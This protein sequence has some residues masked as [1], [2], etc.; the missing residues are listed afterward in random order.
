MLL[1]IDAEDG[2]PGGHGPITVY[3]TIVSNLLAQVSNGHSG[4]LVIGGGKD[5][6]DDVTTFWD[7]IG[8]A[9]G[10]SVTY[11]NGTSNISSQSFAGFA[12]IVVSSSES[13]TSSGGLTDAENTALTAR[14]ISIASHVNGGGALMVF[15]QMG[16]TS[17]YG[18]LAGIGAITSS[19][20][21]S[22]DDENIDVNAAGTAA[23]LSDELD[24]CCWHEQYLSFPSFL[25]PLATYAGSSEIAAIGGASVS[26]PSG[27][28]LAPE[29][30]SV[31]IGQ[32]CTVTAT[33]LRAGQPVTNQSVTFLVTSGPHTGATA[34]VATDGSGNAVFSYPTTATGTDTIS[35]STTIGADVLTD[36][37]TCTIN[38]P[39]PPPTPPPPAH[40]V[41][42][43]PSFTG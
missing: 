19:D 27:L 30:Q 36:T 22:G 6:S 41:V 5:P 12:L 32:M 26:V 2:G 40:P 23:G 10:R 33:V 7:T 25:Q 34:T 20:I 43:V 8:T 4:I 18:F 37:S 29:T 39:A 28:T 42:A 9:I 16:I 14:D 13:E 35:A 17:P 15:T 11:V 38:N 21:G 31:N 3:Q 1:G 24:V